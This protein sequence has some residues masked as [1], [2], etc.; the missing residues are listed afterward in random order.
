MK[1]LSFAML[2]LAFSAGAANAQDAPQ[3]AVD[4]CLKHANAYNDAAPG[5]AKYNGGA[6]KN[7]S[8][9]SAGPGNDWRLRIDVTNGVDLSCTVSADGRSLSLVPIGS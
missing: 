8:I 7:V 6:E 1:L 5:T 4:A 3:A 2:A 9:G